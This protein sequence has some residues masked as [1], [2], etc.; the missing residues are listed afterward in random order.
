MMKGL[1]NFGVYK[2]TIR[3][4]STLTVALGIIPLLQ[5]I[6]KIFEASKEQKSSTLLLSMI[7]L[8]QSSL[9]LSMFLPVC[10]IAT[11]I[12]TITAFNINNQ[13]ESTDFYYALPHKRTA[14]Y[15]S[16][17]LAVVTAVVVLISFICILAVVLCVAFSRQSEINIILMT[18]LK[19]V[20]GSILVASASMLG[21]SFTRNVFSNTIASVCIVMLPRF[22]TIGYTKLLST[23]LP[24]GLI[25]FISNRGGLTEYNIASTAFVSGT[26][27]NI[28]T[29]FVYT[30]L[31]AVVYTVIGVYIFKKRNS[32]ASENKKQAV[33]LKNLYSVAIGIVLFGSVTAFFVHTYLKTKFQENGSYFKFIIVAL[34]IVAVF[35]YVLY[36]YSTNK[37]II[38]TIYKMGIICSICAVF[39][40]CV[41]S[42]HNK[43]LYFC[44]DISEVESMSITDVSANYRG[45]LSGYLG[46]DIAEIPIED[47]KMKKMILKNIN[48]RIKKVEKDP[49]SLER[50][51]NEYDV[52]SWLFPVTI[53]TAPGEKTRVIYFEFDYNLENKMRKI[54][55]QNMAKAVKK[56]KIKIYPDE[57]DMS[58]ELLNKKQETELINSAVKELNSLNS[59]EW[60]KRENKQIREWWRDQEIYMYYEPTELKNINVKEHTSRLTYSYLIDYISIPITS[61]TLPKTY[62]KYCELLK[63]SAISNKYTLPE[64]KNIN[65]FWCSEIYDSQGKIMCED[66]YNINENELA[67]KYYVKRPVREGDMFAIVFRDFKHYIVP[68]E[69]TDEK[70]MQRLLKAQSKYH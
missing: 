7:N 21:I 32:E 23:S 35:I 19:T 47:E 34:Y 51:Y 10:L 64:S 65:K 37:G 42:S 31:V 3:K 2:T 60:L 20:F 46:R 24:Q 43:E 11:L 18:S 5:V 8:E 14:L 6:L 28:I 62:V 33:F 58:E 66:A 38:K 67:R 1:F 13:K 36:E 40:G 68:I 63:E 54:R 4:I 50:S 69:V 61:S 52:D 15:I 59:S 48:S 22:L 16:T 41:V 45:T 25:P 39:F 57:C 26:P 27:K 56:N 53:K 49:F 9:L 17:L 44:P 12:I 55:R 70:D 30:F 29:S